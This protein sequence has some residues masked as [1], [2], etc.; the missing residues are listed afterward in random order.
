MN[1]TIES[2]ATVYPENT[3]SIN[4]LAIACQVPVDIIARTGIQ[5][6]HVASAGVLTSD[7]A[8]DAVKKALQGMNPKQLDQL[9]FISEGVS[10]YLYMDTS[11]CILKKINGR[12]D[13]S[14]YSYDYFRGGSGTIGIIRMVGNQ[15]AANPFISVSAIVTSLLWE[16]H[17]NHRRIGDTFLGDGAGALIL[18][19]DGTRNRIR[20]I[21]TESLSQYNLAA[22]FKYGGTLNDLNQEVIRSHQFVWDVIDITHYDGLLSKIVSTA[23]AAGRKALAAANLTASDIAIVGIS[24]FLR[25][26]S[27]EILI[28]FPCNRVIDPLHD[29]GYLGSL[30]AIDLLE[31]FINDDSIERGETMLAISVGVDVNV[32][33]LI[34]ER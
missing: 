32:E 26:I 6:L 7:M 29:K 17:S 34:I 1:I 31:H 30:G 27:D 21:V 13:G 19:A 10:D 11:K 22:G 8:A 5:C 20:S 2:A 14:I 23:V 33:A 9:V 4:E 18:K 16:Y 15:L 12:V 28:E 3:I 24:G 25:D